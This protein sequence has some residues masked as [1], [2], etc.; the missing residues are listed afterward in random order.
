MTFEVEIM[1]HAKSLK[2]FALKLCRDASQAEDLV[3]TTYLR[4]LIH[5][6]KF[7]M[8]TNL[9]AWLFTILRNQFIQG[10]RK[11][12]RMVEDPEG[13]F[14]ETLRSLPNQEYHVTYM[15]FQKHFDALPKDMQDTLFMVGYEGETYE[16][17]AERLGVATGTAK[18]RVSRARTQLIK[19]FGSMA[20]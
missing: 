13:L 11:S 1:D 12:G 16:A 10:V 9:K 3:Q 19:T 5:K 7:Q 2:A 6:D 14:Q 20:A 15:E 18:S 17:A 8:G 4:A